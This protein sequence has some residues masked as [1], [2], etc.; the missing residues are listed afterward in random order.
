MEAGLRSGTYEMTPTRLL[1]ERHVIDPAH[2][3]LAR[4][5]A[6]LAAAHGESYRL[7]DGRTIGDLDRW[8][9][10]SLLELE[11]EQPRPVGHDRPDDT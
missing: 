3:Q 11:I 9:R 5:M 2:R 8:E 6:E 7:G 10:E 1:L 4:S